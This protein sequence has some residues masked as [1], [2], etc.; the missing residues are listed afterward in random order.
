MGASF[1]SAGRGRLAALATLLAAA[2][3]AFA[4]TTHDTQAPINLEAASSDF[5]YR[6]NTLVFKRVKISQGSL[7]VEAMEASATGLNFE[8]S[9]WTLQGQVR[10]TVPDG[11]LASNDAAVTFRN[12]DI[13]RAVIRGKPATFEQRLED[14]SQVAKGRADTIEYDVQAATVRLIGGAWLSDGQ[15]EIRG[16][17]LVYDIGKQRVAANPGETEPGG[18]HITILPKDNQQPAQPPP[19]APPE[20]TQ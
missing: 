5:D 19:E 13:V 7:Q 3:P 12:N 8:N 15:N 1:H 14:G 2:S 20:R 17:T 9:Q 4:A 11:K 6:N 18:V 16:S 10:I